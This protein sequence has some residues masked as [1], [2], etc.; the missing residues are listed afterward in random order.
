MPSASV[1]VLVLV[2]VLVLDRFG[3]T[4]GVMWLRKCGQV[5]G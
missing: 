4:H 3:I 2:V 5:V 1:I